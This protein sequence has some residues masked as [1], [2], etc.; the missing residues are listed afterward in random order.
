MDLKPYIEY[1]NSPIPW[2]ETL[3]SH[4]KVER[5]KWLFRKMNRPVQDSD[6]VVTCFR[7]GVVTLRKN[8]RLRGFTESLKE[9]GYQGILKGDLVIHAMDAFAG[10][11]GVSDSDGKGTPVY[12]VCKPNIGINS[13]YFAYVIREMSRNR[14]ILAL[15]KGIR[16]RSTDFRFEDFANQFVPL[17]PIEEQNAIVRYLDHI[18]RLIKRY[19]HAKQKE[20][21][22]LNEQKLAIIDQ[23]ATKGL[24]L[25]TIFVPTGN[26]WIESIP[27]GWKLLPL[28]R[29][30]NTKITDGPHETPEL[31]DFGVPFMSAES[32]INGHL[33]FDHKR[34]YITQKT[35]EFFCR[36]CR[37][38]KDDI[39]MCKSGATTGKVAI[40]EADQEFSVWS[41][42]AL[43]RV[44]PKNV[45]PQLLFIILQSTYIQQQVKMTWSF[46]TQQNLSMAAMERLQI[47]LPS[48]TE[49]TDLLTHILDH[50]NNYEKIVQEINNE[51]RLIH[52]YRIRLFSD[53]VTG[54]LDIRKAASCL[55][56]ELVTIEPNEEDF[57]EEVLEEE[58][59]EPEEGE[60]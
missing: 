11:I 36:K 12:S 4:W 29:W 6:E 42:L 31:I 27:T 37:P 22:L 9:I 24:T 43:I 16:E 5:A 20:I 26:I 2:I 54:K 44:N 55:P 32:M 1:K 19:I 15:A 25:N 23:A 52:E 10:A 21:K 17:P 59:S 57:S 50:V 48:I 3:P 14:W 49:Q 13:H 35:H 41:P 45:L 51:I 33:D 56:K 8:R 34:G 58:E 38:Q 18:D 40:V 30:V 60:E 47:A 46:G 53:V 7:D 39:F 28:K